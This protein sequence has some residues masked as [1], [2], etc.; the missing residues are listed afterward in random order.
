MRLSIQLKPLLIFTSRDTSD[1]KPQNTDTFTD[2]INT[3]VQ[4]DIRQ[5]SI[6]KMVEISIQLHDFITKL[7][8]M[9]PTKNMQW[10]Y[11]VIENGIFCIDTELPRDLTEQEYNYVTQM[12]EHLCVSLTKL[13][14][15][16]KI[17]DKNILL[18]VKNEINVAFTELAS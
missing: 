14:I 8:V 17:G 18:S 3:F 15:A 5:S 7:V 9:G 4:P 2:I 16:K 11:S 1:V 13:P 6:D 10:N 12:L